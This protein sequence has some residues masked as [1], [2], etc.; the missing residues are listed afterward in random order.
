M[1]NILSNIWNGN[2]SVGDRCGMY[3][4]EVKELVSLLSQNRKSL[5]SLLSQEQLLLFEK[6]DDHYEEYL[7]R[8]MEHAFCDGVRFA[9]KLLVEAMGERI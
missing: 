5:E 7:L 3:D 9:T 6:Y 8:L 2:I 4:P 1:Q